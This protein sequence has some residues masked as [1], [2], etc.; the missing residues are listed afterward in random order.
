MPELGR[1]EKKPRPESIKFFLSRVEGHSKV[2][3]VE[4]LGEQLF[5][6]TKMND[7]KILVHLTNYYVVSEAEVYEILSQHTGID[8]IV[9]ISAW[10]SYSTGGAMVAKEQGVGLFVIN[11]FLGALN[12][13]GQAFINYVTPAERERRKNQAR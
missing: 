11:E 10:N 9:T 12:F 3:S 2:L 4:Q 13:D 5:Q 7:R 6:I 8:C 1:Y